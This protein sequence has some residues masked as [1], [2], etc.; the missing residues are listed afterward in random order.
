MPLGRSHDR[1]SE[2]LAAMDLARFRQ[3]S[4]RTKGVEAARDRQ[5]FMRRGRC[6][7]CFNLVAELWLLLLLSVVALVTLVVV[8]APTSVETAI[9]DAVSNGW[10]EMCEKVSTPSLCRRTTFST[11]L[12]ISTTDSFG[13]GNSQFGEQA[14][15]TTAILATTTTNGVTSV[16]N[17][18]GSNAASFNM[19]GLVND[20]PVLTTIRAM[21]AT[22]TDKA[23]EQRM[24]QLLSRTL[25][26]SRDDVETAMDRLEQMRLSL[27]Q[28]M[29][30][31]EMIKHLRK[32]GLLDSADN[33]DDGASLFEVNAS[34]LVRPN[35]T[36]VMHDPWWYEDL[37]SEH[38]DD[39]SRTTDGKLVE[40]VSRHTLNLT[41]QGEQQSVH[42]NNN[43]RM[44]ADPE[45]TVF[46][47]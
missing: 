37:D 30:P 43:S 9:K 47:A 18:D 22:S 38:D 5:V 40:R 3:S 25:K 10:T 31:A 8:Y 24:V 29:G 41:G 7:S 26:K 19:D 13:A 27:Q 39:D 1:P 17:N 16:L 32:I 20:H 46:N 36:P 28:D 34:A 14:T 15:M 35:A 44:Y 33:G 45:S 4:S 6:D 23:E 21:L 11:T 2:F 42:V 12:A